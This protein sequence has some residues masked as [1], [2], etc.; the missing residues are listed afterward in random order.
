VRLILAHAAVCDLAWIW[1]EVGDLPNVFFDTAWWNTSDLLALFAFVPPGQILYGSD[2]PYGTPLHSETMAV[3]CA[4]QA[5]LNAEQ[6]RA[7]VGDQARR[8]LAGDE[9]LDLGPAPGPERACGDLLLERAYEFLISAINRAMVGGSTEESV[10]LTRLACAV[11]DDAPQ[12]A[13]CRSVLAL[14]DR[15]EHFTADESGLDHLDEEARFFPALHLLILAA[16][17]AR[18]PLVAVPEPEP[19]DVS[20]RQQG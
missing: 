6:V 14:L 10:A 5:G 9:P 15:H 3:R 11:G 16:T 7:V 19:E 12:A 18:T 8:L 13:T 20:T 17:V 2:A 4:L 1:R